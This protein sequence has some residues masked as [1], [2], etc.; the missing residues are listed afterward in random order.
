MSKIIGVDTANIDNIS[1]LGTGGGGGGTPESSSGVLY[2]EPGGWGTNTIDADEHF[3]STASTLYKAQI[4]S[5]TDIV[6]IAGAR[7]HTFLLSSAGVVY[8]AGYT[9][10]SKMGRTVSGD[11]HEFVQA[12][13]GV[14]KIAAHNNGCWAIKTNGELWWCGDIQRYAQSSNT[15]QSTTNVNYGWLQ[16]GSDSDWIDIVC[17]L[18]YPQY[19]LAIKGSTG[20]EYLYTAGYNQFGKTGLG[21]TSGISYG[22][23]RVKSNSTTDWAETIAKID[24]GYASSIAVTTGGKLFLWGDGN[25]HGNG[26]GTTTDYYY[27]IQAG[28]DTDWETPYFPCGGQNGAYCIKTDGTLY[29]SFSATYRFQIRPDSPNRTFLQCGTDTDY[30]ALR[31]FRISTSSG[32]HILFAKKSGSWYVNWYQDPNNTIYGGT[33][34]G[35][36]TWVALNTFL[37]GNPIDVTVNDIFIFFKD[38]NQSAAQVFAIATGAT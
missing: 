2:F 30:E 29:Y 3:G 1:G 35:Q 6:Q 12:L 9:N 11:A 28:T 19:L 36:N 25:N 18:E 33:P 4:S 27:P 5:R 34:P 21:L 31:S 10:T 13:T 7:Y 23:T 32:S 16:Y 8:S 15:G 24:V 14:S 20:S 37:K 22:F 38:M 17:W 26:Q